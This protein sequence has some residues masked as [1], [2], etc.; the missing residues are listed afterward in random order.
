MCLSW[1][2]CT[3]YLLAC[4]VR[5]IVGGS[6]SVVVAINCYTFDV[7]LTV[8]IQLVCVSAGC[9]SLS[10][11]E[12]QGRCYLILFSYLLFVFCFVFCLFFRLNPVFLY[13]CLVFFSS[14]S[15]SLLMVHSADF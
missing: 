5:V 4:Q 3:S 15:L 12:Y 10:C 8:L 2:L 1:S 14:L 13:T 7:S 6:V 11:P 9:Q